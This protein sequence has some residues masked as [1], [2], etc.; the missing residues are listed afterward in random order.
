MVRHVR[1]C[2]PFQ[3]SGKLKRLPDK[4]QPVPLEKDPGSQVC[5]ALVPVNERLRSAQPGR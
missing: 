4:L 1:L 5:D 3:L 2:Y